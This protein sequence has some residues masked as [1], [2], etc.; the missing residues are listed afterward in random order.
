MSEQISTS[1]CNV[2]LHDLAEALSGISDEHLAVMGLKRLAPE[3]AEVDKDAE[4]KRLTAQLADLDDDAT[5]EW[6]LLTDMAHR[7]QLAV[8]SHGGMSLPEQ[9][10]NGLAKAAELAAEIERLQTE[11]RRL[12]IKCGESEMIESDYLEDEG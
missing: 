1:A 8:G 5:E 12:R 4:I 2:V 6:D 3:S 10:E 11:I 9:I 7:L